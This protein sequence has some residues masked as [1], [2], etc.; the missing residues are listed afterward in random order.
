MKMADVIAK[1]QDGT[2]TLY[3][4]RKWQML[5]PGGRWNSHFVYCEKMAGVIAKWEDGTVTLY[6]IRKW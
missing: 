3:G 4:I 2:A 5:L 6:G 1:W